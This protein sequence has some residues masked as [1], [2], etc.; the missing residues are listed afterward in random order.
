MTTAKKNL[1]KTIL[2]LTEKDK[3]LTP[4]SAAQEKI[5]GGELLI[6][7]VYGSARLEG[8]KLSREEVHKIIASR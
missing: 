7:S 8:S 5:I 1:I 6:D 3:K 2:K 4:L